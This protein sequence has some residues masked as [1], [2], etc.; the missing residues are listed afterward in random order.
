MRKR[1][2]SVL[3]AL[4]GIGIGMGRPA[5][6]G[7]RLRY[8]GDLREEVIST[9]AGDSE[10]DPGGRIVGGDEVAN[11][12]RLSGDL[13]WQ[14]SPRW[15]VKAKAAADALL[16]H[17]RRLRADHLDSDFVLRDLY[18]NG[19]LGRFQLSAGRKILKWS[20]GY[21]F[22]P[23]GILDP[24]RDPAD[25]RD[26]LGRVQGRDMVQLDYY[27]GSHTVT[28]AFSTTGRFWSQPMSSEGIVALRYHF[29]VKGLELSASAGLRPTAKDVGTLGFDYTIGQRIGLHGEVAGT[30]GTDTL[31]P[32][33]IL[34]GNQAILFGH[35]FEAPLRQ[36]RDALY[37]RYLVGLNYTFG[38]GLNVIAE[39]YHADEGL[40]SGEWDG[41]IAQADYSRKLFDTG[42]FPP[43]FDGRSIPE[44]NL[45]QAMQVLRRGS[46]RRDYLFV[47]AAHAL[48]GGRLKGE[49]LG[50]IGLNDRSFMLAPEVSFT[51]ASR[52]LAYI[53][54][55]AFIG[56]P[57]TEFGSIPTGPSASA[58]IV[59]SF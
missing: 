34:P 12:L 22:S 31:F 47:R 5:A 53:R 13:A 39:Y 30:R 19:S 11:R 17:D 42:S 38:N 56:R 27:G 59:I 23:A 20:N 8:R 14:L 44:L 15:S 32:R 49:L 55:T 24:V 43:A 18:L 26:R 41:F 50:L 35:D 3:G 28:V 36:Q 21:A 40:T 33:S 2:R 6:A 16:G 9:A 52:M 4:I 10:L 1:L 48:A 46:V 57:Q 51:P 58:G 7:D 25:P 29:V 45:L 37:L 54:G